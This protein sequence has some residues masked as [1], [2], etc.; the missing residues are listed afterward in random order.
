[1]SVVEVEA[2]LVDMILDGRIDA[3]IDQV[4]NT[5]E[6]NGRHGASAANLVDDK[7]AALVDWAAQ[8]AKATSNLSA[9]Y[10]S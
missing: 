5:L 1:M 8:L 7:Q 4:H 2:L 9:K 10:L 6:L 3:Y